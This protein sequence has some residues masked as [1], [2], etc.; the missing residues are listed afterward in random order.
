MAVG[1]AV[2]VGLPSPPSEEYDIVIVGAGMA[3]L[4]AAIA[5]YEAGVRK[6]VVLEKAPIPEATR[7]L[8]AEASLYR[9][10]IS[11]PQITLTTL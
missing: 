9:P 10:R 6:I 2:T 11:R 1:S 8:L 3:G 7:Q 4:T 5:A